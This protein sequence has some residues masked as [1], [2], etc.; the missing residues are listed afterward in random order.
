MS[1]AIQ[2]LN[3]NWEL[4]NRNCAFKVQFYHILKSF[5]NKPLL[6]TWKGKCFVYNKKGIFDSETILFRI[7][8]A[9]IVLN[10]LNHIYMGLSDLFKALREAC[11]KVMEM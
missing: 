3:I 2:R 5:K 9:K 8:Y 1:G 7:N 6:V 4:I 10:P 11:K